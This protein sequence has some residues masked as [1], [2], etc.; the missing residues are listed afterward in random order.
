VTPSLLT[1]DLPRAPVAIIGV[2]NLLMRDDAFGPTLVRRLEGHPVIAALG[3]QV[4]LVDAGTAGFD[5]MHHLLG[6]ERVILLDAIAPHPH[7]T[8]GTVRVLTHDALLAMAHRQA[9]G[10]PH[11][12]SILAA[13]HVA[14]LAGALPHVSLVGMVPGDVS[15]GLGLTDAVWA[16]MGEAEEAAVGVTADG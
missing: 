9:R 13:L 16:A 1:V 12:P 5:L 4:E 14:E 2:G 7:D 15:M 10:T 6:R 11:E 8:P 3:D